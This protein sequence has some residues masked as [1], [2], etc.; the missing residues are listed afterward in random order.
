MHSPSASPCPRQAQG[1][2]PCTLA[3][4]HPCFS[5][6]FPLL[7]SA[8]RSL[9]QSGRSFPATHLIRPFPLQYGVSPCLEH[10]A[11]W[12]RF[13]LSRASLRGLLWPSLFTSHDTLLTHPAQTR[14]PHRAVPFKSSVSMLLCLARKNSS[15]FFRTQLGHGIVPSPSWLLTLGEGY[16]LFIYYRT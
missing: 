14:S 3:Q 11:A 8:W 12:P 9:S 1:Y 7:S 15:P 10:K 6:F 4:P 5:L 2:L 13:W 16:L